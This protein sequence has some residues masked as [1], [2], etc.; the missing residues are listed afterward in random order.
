MS[1]GKGE[2]VT[3]NRDFKR[4]VRK[5]MAAT[6]E[7]YTVARSHFIRSE[8]KESSGAS[9]ET[10]TVSYY[11]DQIYSSVSPDLIGSHI[12]ERHA[13]E[14]SRVDILDLGVFRVD[15]RSGPSWVARAFPA[16]RSDE[17][18][19][20]DFEMLDHLQRHSFP[21]ERLTGPDAL[22]RMG[23][24]WVI[25]TELVPGKNR[26][27]DPS[28]TLMRSLGDMVGW[29]ASLPVGSLSPAGS[30][31][32]LAVNGG[33]RATDIEILEELLA[34]VPGRTATV[35]ALRDE[36]RSLE[37]LDGLP[38]API[39]PDPCSANVIAAH[40]RAPVLIDWTG[41]GRG[42]RLSAFAN[43]IS[44]CR[45]MHLVEAAAEGYR[46]RVTLEQTELERL[47]AALVT[48]PMIL[49]CWSYLFQ[50]VAAEAV[51]SQAEVHKQ[52]AKIIAETAITALTSD[53]SPAKEPP[54]IHEEQGK[55][56]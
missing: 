17:A 15:L 41:A 49:A 23:D 3:D 24:R 26:R 4:L 54:A 43:L 47:E 55:L 16:V 10:A 56:F 37:T 33:P 1:S 9:A 36:L 34:E 30:W 32:H 46:K 19:K 31:H 20:A 39:H 29:L 7:P 45:S 8:D 44:P 42:P 28:A 27:N 11:K 21:A 40:D 48:F 14:V 5:R 52:R 50:E 2:T 51:L 6:G 12:Q 38:E 53:R 25:T 22:T 18:C 13:V 35:S